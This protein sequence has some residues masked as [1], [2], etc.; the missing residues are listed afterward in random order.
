MKKIVE[1][2]LTSVLI[3]ELFSKTSKLIIMII[4]F[5]GLYSLIYFS[6]NKQGWAS[7][8]IKCFSSQNTPCDC[9]LVL[10][11]SVSLLLFL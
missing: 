4:I 7:D 9:G 6:K 8:A 10:N 5:V 1:L 11:Y 2:G 3:S